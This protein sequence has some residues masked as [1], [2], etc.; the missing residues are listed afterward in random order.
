MDIH[1]FDFCLDRNFVPTMWTRGLENPICASVNSEL[2]VPLNHR[3]ISLLPVIEKIY[4]GIML[5]RVRG[6]LEKNDSLTNKQNGFWPNQSC[7]DHILTLCDLLRIWKG[8]NEETFCS[9]MDFQKAFHDV[10][11]NFLFHKLLQVGIC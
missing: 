9:F 4:T 6:F 11:H 1:I 5:F 3:R 10:N 7:L 8:R 2:K